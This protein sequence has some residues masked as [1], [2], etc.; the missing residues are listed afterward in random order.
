MN[1]H[2]SA[3]AALRQLLDHG[4][5]DLIDFDKLTAHNDNT[6]CRAIYL[7]NDTVESF[8]VFKN[9]RYT[10]T[11]SVDYDDAIEY[12]LDADAGVLRVNQGDSHLLLFFDSVEMETHY[13][14]YGGIGHFWVKG[15]ENLRNIEFQIAVIRD[16][17]DYLGPSSCN[18]LETK[19]AM[20]KNFPPL[21][22][23]FY[24]AVPDKYLTRMENPWIVTED[25]LL[26]FEEICKDVDDYKMALL[27]QQYKKSILQSVDAF[28]NNTSKRLAKHIAKLLARPSHKAV[29]DR[30]HALLCQ[31]ASDYP[32]RS[33]GTALDAKITTQLE[34]AARL[35][36]E[37]THGN[38]TAVV[39]RE[40]PFQNDC[41]DITF[42]VYVM[43]M[44]KGVFRIHLGIEEIS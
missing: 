26:V 3:L 2:T 18:A 38:Q 30:I 25:A 43:T 44:Q 41:D 6:D 12:S 23:L 17:Y 35:A 42:K 28:Q 7:M 31:A 39:Y 14:N 21:N 4:L 32:R 8:L 22:Y 34:K 33:F 5:F 10:G 24:P 11:Y 1:Q 9:A 19:L 13:Y 40:E 36:A 20:L 16:K 15:Y 29:P 37:L 27:V